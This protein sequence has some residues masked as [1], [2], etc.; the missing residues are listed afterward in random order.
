MNLIYV[1]LPSYINTRQRIQGIP[2]IAPTRGDVIYIQSKKE[3]RMENCINDKDQEDQ[4]LTQTYQYSRQGI[5]ISMTKE[6]K[7]TNK[8]ILYLSMSKY[9]IK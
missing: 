6:I 8:A 2:V 7:I 4:P 9:Q 5:H 1:Q 3:A